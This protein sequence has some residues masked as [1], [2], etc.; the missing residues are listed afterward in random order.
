MTTK[1]PTAITAGP[2]RGPL[3]RAGGA[4]TASSRKRRRVR[5]AELID[6]AAYR[7]DRDDKDPW[8]PGGGQGAALPIPQL[9]VDLAAPQPV[10]AA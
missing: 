9:L 10:W 2:E 4:A 6:L 5:T 1:T 3:Y 8:P 7:A